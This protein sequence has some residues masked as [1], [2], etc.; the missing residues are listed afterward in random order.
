MSSWDLIVLSLFGATYIPFFWFIGMNASSKRILD[1]NKFYDVDPNVLI[2]KWA[3][4]CTKLFFYMHYCFFLI[5]LTLISWLHGLA[6]FGAGVL[7]F[8]FIPLSSKSYL[9][10][11][12]K[13][14]MRIYKQDP[15]TG[16]QLIRALRTGT[17][18]HGLNHIVEPDNP[19]VP[20]Q[21]PK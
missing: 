7:L 11:F 12:K 19:E 3:M 10:V 15:G 4:R 21:P 2:P 1:K 9:V 16:K 13:N 18:A 5:P 17:R 20:P 8:V 14:A 6:A